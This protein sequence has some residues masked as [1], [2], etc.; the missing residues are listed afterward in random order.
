MFGMGSG[1]MIWMAMSLL[2]AWRL[3]NNFVVNAKEGNSEGQEF[4]VV[5]CT[6]PL[7]RLT[8][9]LKCKWGIEYD[10]GDEVVTWKYH[11]NGVTMIHLMFY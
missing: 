4:W 7:H 10:V 2:L 6:K 8:S 5:C 9:P 3:A 11:K 1:S